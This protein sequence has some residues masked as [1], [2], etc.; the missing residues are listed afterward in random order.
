[1]H[2]I[3]LGWTTGSLASRLFYTKQSE[4]SFYFYV[5]FFS[6]AHDWKNNCFLWRVGRCLI[7]ELLEL[8]LGAG[9]LGDLE[10]VEVH[11]VAQG[12]ALT[13]WD[14]VTNLDIP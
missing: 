2:P 10:H 6:W 4:E 3:A 8:L 14:S 12:L 5:Y 9:G 11:S 7:S 13:Q 1:M